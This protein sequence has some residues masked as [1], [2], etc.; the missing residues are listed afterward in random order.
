MLNV[1]IVENGILIEIDYQVKMISWDYFG[2]CLG[3]V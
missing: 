1:R 3:D 2:R